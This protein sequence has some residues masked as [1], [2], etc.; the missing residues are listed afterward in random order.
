VESVAWAT[1]RRDVLSGVW[2]LLTILLYLRAVETSGRRRR[3][4]LALSVAA[5][6]L[7]LLSK[8]IVM[9]LPVVLILLDVYPLRRLAATREDGRWR[10]L[11]WEKAPYLALSVAGAVMA[12][13]A[14]AVLEGPKTPYASSP[15][16]SRAANIAYSL[17]FYAVK[18]F[19]P[20]GLSPL[21]EAPPHIDPFE[22]RFAVG[23]LGVAGLSLVMVLLRSKWPGGLTQWLYYGVVLAP[24]LRCRADGFPARR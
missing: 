17:W 6:L 3:R 16:P 15:W 11:L 4:L 2:F 10:P 18:T 12:Y 1:E 7:A 5:Y 8:A 9:T 19:V 14:Q 20:A 13:L 21:Y 22:A 24:G 23:A